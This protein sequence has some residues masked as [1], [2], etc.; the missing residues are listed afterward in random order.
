MN[1]RD[2]ISAKKRTEIAATSET[3][4]INGSRINRSTSAARR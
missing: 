2:V 1:F 3:N 4:R